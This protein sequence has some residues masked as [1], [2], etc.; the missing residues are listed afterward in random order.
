MA[1]GPISKLV[2]ADA[3]GIDADFATDRRRV[4]LSADVCS[5]RSTWKAPGPGVWIGEQWVSENTLNY[6]IIAAIYSASTATT[7]PITGISQE[8]A[9]V[10]R[11]S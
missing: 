3:E 10:G 6:Q 5:T 1:V 4:H 11:N 8:A 9:G 7:I 2:R